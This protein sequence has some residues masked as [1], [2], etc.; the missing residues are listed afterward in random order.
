[1]I[2]VFLRLK[3][4]DLIFF[5]R[6]CL[7]KGEVRVMAGKLVAVEI[8]L[9]SCSLAKTLNGRKKESMHLLQSSLV[10]PRAGIASRKQSSKIEMLSGFSDMSGQSW[11]S[12]IVFKENVQ[13]TFGVAVDITEAM[14]SEVLEEFLRFMAGFVLSLG[15]DVM[16]DAVKPVGELAAAPIN[17]FAK[18]IKKMPEP[19]LIACGVVDIRT[20]DIPAKGDV[21]IKIALSSPREV[22]KRSRRTVNKKTKI[23]KKVLMKKGESNGELTLSIRRI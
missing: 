1:V 10:W 20:D 23:T 14:G 21:L 5:L 4:K 15:A 7:I 22:V 3:N 2:R 16:E 19:A 9:V 13:S 17:Y 8:S 12:R 11:S 6:D 18:K